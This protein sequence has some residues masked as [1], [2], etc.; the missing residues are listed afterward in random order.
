MPDILQYL[1]I[2]KTN[3]HIRLAYFLSMFLSFWLSGAG[4]IHLV[5]VAVMAAAV[6]SCDILFLKF[7]L[8]TEAR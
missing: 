8:T 7:T 2:L 1:N 4:L 3:N 5:S 6:L